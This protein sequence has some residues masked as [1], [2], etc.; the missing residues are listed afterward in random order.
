MSWDAAT[1]PYTD[2]VD[3][4]EIIT[5][6]KDTPGAFLNSTAVRGKSV[7]IDGLKPGHHYLVAVATWNAAGG[8]MPGV[9]RP[10]TDGAGT[11]PAPTDLKVTST[12]A[13]TVQLSWNGSVWAAGYRV[14]VRNVDDS[15]G[16]KH[17]GSGFKA[18]EY[19]TSETS[20]GI[21]FLFPGAWNYEFCV[22]AINGEAESGKSNCV[23]APKPSAPEDGTKGT[24][25]PPVPED[26]T[27]GA[28]LSALIRAPRAPAGLAG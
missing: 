22:T 15:T 26:G 1:G 25:R 23:I 10:V 18:D 6:D 11:P 20:R 16:S 21:A 9:A 14:W 27:K 7:H 12:D 2:T 28:P 13:T 24:S 17:D 8:G 19:I 5:W 4:Y 3:R